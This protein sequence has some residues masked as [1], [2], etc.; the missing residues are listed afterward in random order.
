MKPIS[1][2]P[3]R[4]KPLPPAGPRKRDPEERED[5]HDQG[6][7]DSMAASDPVSTVM[8]D[9]KKKGSE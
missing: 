7:E 2:Q 4:E 8:P 9:V 3:K 1:Q 5:V 6:V